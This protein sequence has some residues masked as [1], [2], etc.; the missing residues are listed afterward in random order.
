MT[1]LLILHANILWKQE[2][3]LS[4]RSIENIMKKIEGIFA[5]IIGGKA[6]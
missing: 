5:L 2:L 4:D 6:A 3:K 1:V